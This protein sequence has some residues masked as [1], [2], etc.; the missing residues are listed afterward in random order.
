MSRDPKYGNVETSLSDKT[1]KKL[2]NAETRKDH[3][4]QWQPLQCINAN[5]SKSAPENSD[6]NCR[7][8]HHTSPRAHTNIFILPFL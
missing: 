5:I 7:I 2:T 3:C 1:D 8:S 6:A 4:N